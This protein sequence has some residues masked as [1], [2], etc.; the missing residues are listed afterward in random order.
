T[1]W[2]SEKPL[3]RTAP[4]PLLMLSN[5]VR[6]SG[7]KVV[8]TG[9]GADEV[10]GGYNIFKEAKVRQFWARQ[11]ESQARAALTG[12]LY[13]Y[14]F[15]DPRAKHFLKSFFAAGLDGH[16]DP[17]F[18]H[19]VRWQ[20]TSR[21]KAFFSE[22]LVAAAGASD[23]YEQIQ[24]S[25]PD[26]YE[27]MDTVAKAQYIETKIFLS[28]YLLSSQ[29]DRMAMAN[30]LEIRVPFLDYRVI[31]FMA[32][33]PSR[34]KILGLS[35]KHIL[36]R[37]LAPVLPGRV[38]RRHKQPYRAPIANGLL[39]EGNGDLIAE[40]LN[41]RAIES[42]GLFDAGRVERLLNKARTMPSLGEIDN[43]ALAGVLSS[44]VIHRRFIEDFSIDAIP[45]VRLNVVVDRRSGA[46]QGL[47]EVSPGRPR[48][49]AMPDVLGKGR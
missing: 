29:G 5:T 8:L 19:R 4:V 40:M 38:C 42:A 10:F 21:I 32:R 17:L 45:A 37:A 22:E 48:S 39:S 49:A 24:A 15:R 23:V 7:L 35:E 18:S 43:M 26:D 31:E 6:H 30:S 2:H 14:V 34:W 11:P 16:D 3:L 47:T 12:R 20:N 28:S 46:R 41:R 25:L 9:E 33:V 44:Q 27:E 1:L 13:G 36:K